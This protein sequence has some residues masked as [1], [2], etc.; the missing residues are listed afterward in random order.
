MRR[1]GIQKCSIHLSCHPQR[2]CSCSLFRAVAATIAQYRRTPGWL[3]N[4][5]SMCR[6]PDATPVKHKAVFLSELVSVQQREPRCFTE[7]FVGHGLLFRRRASV[8][9]GWLAQTKRLAG[10]KQRIIVHVCL[11]SRQRHA[12]HGISYTAHHT[13]HITHGTSHTTHHRDTVTSSTHSG[14]LSHIP[15]PTKEP[16]VLPSC[17]KKKG[18]WRR[19]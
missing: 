13:R 3:S 4:N 12:T 8:R 16:R 10:T 6:R 5:P 17:G 15:N 7:S 14:P 19:C 11:R 18:R 1:K 9:D 2:R